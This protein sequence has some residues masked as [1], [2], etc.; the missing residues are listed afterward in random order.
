MNKHYGFSWIWVKLCFY[1]DQIQGTSSLKP[2]D[3]TLIVG[4]V[5]RYFVMRSIRMV[6]DHLQGFAWSEAG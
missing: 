6:E 3:L 5:S 2:F 4:M 1:L